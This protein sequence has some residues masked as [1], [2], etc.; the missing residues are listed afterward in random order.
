[1]PEGGN[2]RLHASR[3][4]GRLL[5]AVSDDG[6]GITTAVRARLGEPFFTTK[7]KGS[8]LG[9]SIVRRVAESHGGRLV[10]DSRPGAGSK[11]T[12][13]LPAQPVAGASQRDGE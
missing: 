9:L 3:Q 12:L 1:M 4:G 2:V 11:F 10:V 8:G 13:V 5:L 6:P 7:E